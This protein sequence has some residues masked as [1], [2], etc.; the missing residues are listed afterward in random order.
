[1]NAVHA[2]AA[3]QRLF[4][5]IGTDALPD[6]VIDAGKKN[7][8]PVAVR[9]AIAEQGRSYWN[10]EF[11]EAKKAAKE[12]GILGSDDD[13]V[14]GETRVVASFSSFDITAKKANASEV[15]DKTALMNAL[16]KHA[17]A[18]VREKVLSE[19]IKE[20]KGAVTI[21]VALK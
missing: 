7:T 20:R 12:A 4:K 10:K 17:S 5:Q 14:T 15:V 16:N 18:S 8:A 9:F 6:T 2:K 11:E 13:Y 21:S 19:C 1:M 3:I